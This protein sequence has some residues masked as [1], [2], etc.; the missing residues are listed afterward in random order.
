MSILDPELEREVK[1]ACAKAL[2]LAR[3]L[4]SE[5]EIDGLSKLIDEAREAM[6]RPLVECQRR[7]RELVGSAE[8][9]LNNAVRARHLRQ[10]R[11]LAAAALPIVLERL[12]Q[13]LLSAGDVDAV[14]YMAREIRAADEE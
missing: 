8:K 7:W 2:E 10:G 11:K 9:A 4:E 3:L 5:S 13:P 1:A 14:L 12:R 6:G